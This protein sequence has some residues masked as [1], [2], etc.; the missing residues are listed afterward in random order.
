ME[1][2]VGDLVMLSMHNL[3]MYNN[4]KFAAHFIGPLNMLKYVGK[5]AYHIELPP[6]YSALHNI[7][8]MS[9]LNLYVS[10]G[11]D[12]T[13]T[14]IQLVL[15]NGEEQY[16]MEKI[17]AECGCGNHKQFLVYWVSYSTKHDFQLPESELT[18]AL[19]VPSV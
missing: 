10:D 17:V 12:G 7:F 11:S 4:C 14:N 16:E 5:L 13:S 1:F 19:D 18:Q 2:V 15:V 8:H 6:I 9:M 3:C